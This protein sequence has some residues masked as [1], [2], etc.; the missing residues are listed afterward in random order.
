MIL[1][2]LKYPDPRLKLK[3]EPIT[4]ITPEIKQLAADMAV[5]MYEAEG[6]GL[7]APQVGQLLRMIVVD[8]SG[9]SK[10]EAL[11]VYINP[12]ITPAPPKPGEDKTQRSEEG[13]LS[14]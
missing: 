13:C 6:I 12:T 14:V 11:R 9:P 10:R 8:L 5:T 7:A 2:I 3:S 1:E 4:H